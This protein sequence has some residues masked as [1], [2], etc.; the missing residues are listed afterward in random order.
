MSDVSVKIEPTSPDL[1]CQISEESENYKIIL[2]YYWPVQPVISTF[3]PG[4]SLFDINFLLP[5][6]MMRQRLRNM[7]NN[8][9]KDG[10]VCGEVV[11]LA[12]RT[13]PLNTFKVFCE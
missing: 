12:F 5:Y 6:L 13:H 1:Y 2:S 10:E 7:F 4:L 8:D 3:K 11:Y 9:C